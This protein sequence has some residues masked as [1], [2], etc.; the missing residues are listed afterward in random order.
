MVWKNTRARLGNERNLLT[1]FLTG[2]RVSAGVDMYN[3]SSEEV[4]ISGA[5]HRALNDIVMG[6]TNQHI[7]EWRGNYKIFVGLDGQ[8]KAEPEERKSDPVGFQ[9]GFREKLVFLPTPEWVYNTPQ[10]IYICFSYQLP[11][12]MLKWWEKYANL[13][14]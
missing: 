4:V 1:Y 10:K 3:L 9:S 6:M 7:S 2:G 13:L 14:G 11:D 5:V 8:I 12:L